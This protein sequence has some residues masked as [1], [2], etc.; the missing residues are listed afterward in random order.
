MSVWRD[1]G[2]G[3]EDLECPAD[4]LAFVCRHGGLQ[5]S[6]Y[7]SLPSHLGGLGGVGRLV[8]GTPIRGQLDRSFQWP[9]GQSPEGA[10]DFGEEPAASFRMHEAI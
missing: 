10:S 2:S 8:A 7:P 3:D 5:R 6:S 1:S 9:S 4:V